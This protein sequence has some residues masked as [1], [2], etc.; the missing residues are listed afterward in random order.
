MLLREAQWLAR[1]IEELGGARLYPMVNLGSQTEEFRVRTQPWIDQYLF[2]PARRHNRKVVHVDLQDAPG[3]DL[4]GDL[5]EPVFLRRLAELQIQSVL[6]NNLLEH[7][8]NRERIAAA[9]VE[10]LP[11]GGHVFLT[12]PLRFPYHPNPIDTM[13]RPRLHELLELFPGMHIVAGSE[14]ACG[15]ILHYVLARAWY[16]PVE[17][18]RQTW[19]TL[20][21]RRRSAQ[22]SNHT[23]N[24]YQAG[25]AETLL[26]W[27]LE[28]VTTTCAVLRKDGTPASSKVG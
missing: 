28:T 12:V 2:A 27:L 7:V 11:P 4:V 6:C 25:Q 26:P 5:T 13:Y 9:I 15:T 17:V 24:G 1:R 19:G 14:L 21:A 10:L 3:V 8:T 18:F 20:K 22:E 16:T 23:S